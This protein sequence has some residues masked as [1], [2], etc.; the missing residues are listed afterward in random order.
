MCYASRSHPAS[1][2]LPNAHATTGYYGRAFGAF[3][4]EASFWFPCIPVYNAQTAFVLAS[5]CVVTPGVANVLSLAYA[6]SR[7]P[8]PSR[9]YS[10]S[11]VQRIVLRNALRRSS[12]RLAR[13]C[14]ENPSPL[15]VRSTSTALP[16][17]APLLLSE[18][19]RRTADI[20]A[21]SAMDAVFIGMHGAMMVFKPPD[22]TRFTENPIATASG[23]AERSASPR[24]H[25]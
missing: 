10:L 3:R 23:L 1:C 6:N 20:T 2:A 11:R 8:A 19:G 13:L 5:V 17:S 25:C 21:L 4:L 9:R 16:V 7:R 15:L 12:V 22:E 14:G 24:S 18:K